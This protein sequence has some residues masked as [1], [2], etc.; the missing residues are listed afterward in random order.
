MLSLTARV[1]VK[2]TAFTRQCTTRRR[3]EEGWGRKESRRTTAIVREESEPPSEAVKSTVMATTDERE[4]DRQRERERERRARYSPNPGAILSALLSRGGAP[5]FL[6]TRPRDYIYPKRTCFF[7][8]YAFTALLPPIPCVY[9][10]LCPETPIDRRDR[11]QST[12]TT[13]SE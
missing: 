8:P 4:K 5:S 11:K 10:P 9:S 6:F 7:F 1:R 2:V 13:P 3:L 12:P